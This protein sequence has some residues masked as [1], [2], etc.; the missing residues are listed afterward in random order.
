MK[1]NKE[2]KSNRMLFQVSNVV[3]KFRLSE[4]QVI[5]VFDGINLNI[6]VGETLGLFGPNG[7]GKSTL[8][9]LLTGLDEV[10]SGAVFYKDEDFTQKTESEK[11]KIRGK[12]FGFLYPGATY[13]SNIT[14]K[15]NI[16]VNLL[17][18]GIG[19]LD[20]I[21]IIKNISS[22]FG[23]K[24]L[25]N[26]NINELTNLE[27]HTVCLAAAV[28]KKPAILFVDEFGISLTNSEKQ[29]IYELILQYCKENSITLILSS[30][31]ISVC[32]KASRI[33]RFENG[34]IN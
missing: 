20:S 29:T 34:K 22:E 24:E 12:E 10:D 33:V 32:S 21:E 19:G 17:A 4:T 28:S 14:A 25:L 13:I 9:N 1:K 18:S 23:I 5:T 6:R 11:D 3:K 15:D 26:K 30:D 2:R 16:E 27:I 31:D 8:I 7:S